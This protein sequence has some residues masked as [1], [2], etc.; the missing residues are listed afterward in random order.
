[1]RKS[2][3]V[4]MIFFFLAGMLSPLAES[5][6]SPAPSPSHSDKSTHKGHYCKVSK[7]PCKHGK[8]C[9]KKHD[10]AHSAHHSHG[11]DDKGHVKKDSK[12]KIQASCHPLH[13]VKI[14]KLVGIDKSFLLS[15]TLPGAITFLPYSAASD[16]NLYDNH[17]LDVPSRPPAKI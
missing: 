10:R 4:F 5:F 11:D 14:L 3:I 2:F 1:M 8:S 16:H 17:F 6:A 12:V 13:D 9:P 15:F 7:G